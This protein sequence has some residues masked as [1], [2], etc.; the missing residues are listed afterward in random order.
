[1]LQMPSK[2]IAQWGARRLLIWQDI[3]VSSI[4]DSVTNPAILVVHQYCYSLIGHLSWIYWRIKKIC[5]TDNKSKYHNLNPSGLSWPDSRQCLINLFRLNEVEAFIEQHKL[6][7]V[8]SCMRE[9]F[10]YWGVIVLCIRTQAIDKLFDPLA[11]Q[12]LSQEANR[13]LCDLQE[14]PHAWTYSWQLLG[15]DKVSIHRQFSFP[16]FPIPYDL[17]PNLRSE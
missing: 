2:Q 1:M 12:V 9:T 7:L 16:Y 14:C 4:F 15:L 17:F 13:F 5:E 8:Y 6:R 10:S 11:S 3:R